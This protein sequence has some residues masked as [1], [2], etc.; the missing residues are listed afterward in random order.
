MA[1]KWYIA[2]RIPQSIA[3][4][5]VAIILNFAIMHAAPGSPLD[6][7][8]GAGEVISPEYAA[9]LK[10]EF[11]L[12]KPL[13]EQLIIYLGKVLVGDF[14]YSFKYRQPVLDIIA[15][16]V[17]AT[18]LLTGS[19]ILFAIV[20]GILLGVSASKKP[21]SILD[22]FASTVTLLGYSTPTFWLGMILILLLSVQMRLFPTLGMT[23]A[24]A[25]LTG[26]DA[27]VDMLSHLVLPM[28]TLGTVYL[29][30]YTR[31][32][33]ASMLEELKKDYILT[34][35]SKGLDERT[36]YYGHAFRNAML[37]VVT[38]LGLNLGL[39]L[40]GATLTETV[41]AWPGL[42]RLVYDSL[43]ARDYPVLMGIFV[44][45]SIS[46]ILANFIVDILYAFLDPRIRY[47]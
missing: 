12:D 14:G 2:R 19:S 32:T 39:M 17:P 7:L 4:V 26:W 15:T 22:N 8:V 16:R 38:V 25:E 6:Y 35:W 30:L 23:S 24:G 46:V 21:Y 43:L 31:L 20:L 27:V 33:R 47:K 9:R 3:L 37:P 34:A 36:V 13:Y 41:F 44:I 45:V 29:A 10:A 28:V 40:T 18:V 5:F 42:G 11:G 1:L